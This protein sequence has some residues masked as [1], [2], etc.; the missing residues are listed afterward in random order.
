MQ[1]IFNLGLAR[2]AGLSTLLRIAYGQ[3]KPN[4]ENTE[5]MKTNQE[6]IDYIESAINP[7]SEIGLA[8]GTLAA[9]LELADKNVNAL[10]QSLIAQFQS[11]G[12]ELMAETVSKTLKL[13]HGA[14]GRH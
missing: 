10:G 3:T 9:R 13:H 5:T 12:N 7:S 14:M 11:C 1:E 6:I 2:L 4:Q 8:L